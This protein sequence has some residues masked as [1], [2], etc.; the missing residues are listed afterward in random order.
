MNF[1]C[2]A[3]RRILTSITLNVLF[4]LSSIFTGGGTRFWNRLTGEP[5]AHVQPTRPGTVLTHSAEIN[6]EG[7]QVTAGT[8]MILVGFL[9]VDRRNPS[10]RQSTGLSLYASAGCL[11]WML[12]RFKSAYK[13]SHYR[14]R[15]QADVEAGGSA[16]SPEEGRASSFWKDNL[17]MRMLY[18]DLI[19]ILQGVGDSIAPHFVAE[20]VQDSNAEAYLAALDAAAAPLTTGKAMWWK[21]QQLNV[22]WDGTVDSTWKTRQDHREAFSELL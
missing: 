16:D 1:V 8:R 21:G 17:Y 9:S 20:L 18:F 15:R 19:A 5:F 2:A 14:L 7:V 4:C 22:D 3:F 13:L 11:T 10:S 6:H 12:K